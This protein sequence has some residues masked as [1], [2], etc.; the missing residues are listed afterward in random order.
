MHCWRGRIRALEIRA[1]IAGYCGKGKALDEA[2]AERAESYGDQTERRSR[3]SSGGDQSWK[4]RG[5]EGRADIRMRDQPS[6]LYK[7]DLIGEIFVL[8][9]AVRF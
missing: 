3:C 7:L 4:Y 9:V 8:V 2:L 1:R 5:A 6:L